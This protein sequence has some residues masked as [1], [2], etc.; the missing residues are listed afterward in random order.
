[1]VSHV[2]TTLPGGSTD[3]VE[4]LYRG[5]DEL[6]SVPAGSQSGLRI[7]VLFTDGASNGVPGNWDGSGVAKSLRTYDFPK[8]FPDPDGQTW[9][10]P[11]IGG[12]YDTASATS[13]ASPSVSLHLPTW[14]ATN[15]L[16]GYPFMPPTSL[17]THHRSGGIPTTFPLQT[18]AINVNGMPQSARRGLRNG[19]PAGQFPAD[20]WNINNAARNLLEII[21]N[22]A[23]NDNG[24]YKIRIYTIGMGDLVQY[25]LGTMPEKPSDI[26]KRI[27]NDPESPDHNP[28]QLDG[29][30]FWAQTAAGV[31]PAFQGIQNQILRLSK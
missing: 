25:N 14:N 5:W 17:H 29:K 19:T 31:G 24:D 11:T 8:N 27:S 2:P 30:F 20:V 18:A 3:M 26:L 21:A 9:N 28:N 23:R 6:R 13:G 22:E 4:G 12:L 10:D 15:T 16:G 7:I 1:V